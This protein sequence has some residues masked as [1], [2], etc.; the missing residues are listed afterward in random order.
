LRSISIRAR[1]RK[2]RPAVTARWAAIPW[3]ARI[4]QLGLCDVPQFPAAIFGRSRT[5]DF[6]RE[7]FNLFNRPNLDN[8][9]DPN[10]SSPG[11]MIG[12]ASFG[13]ITAT[14]SP[15]RILQFSLKAVF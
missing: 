15:A 8:P 12:A 7:F 10:L 2:R 14:A 6:P 4:R 1:W 11:N 13:Q 9:G 5:S 3:W